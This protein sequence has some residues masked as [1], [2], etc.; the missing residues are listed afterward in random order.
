MAF[1]FDYTMQKCEEAVSTQLIFSVNNCLYAVETPYILEI[2]EIKHVA[3]LP[4][5]APYVL[6]VTKIRDTIYSVMD[7]RI[8]FDTKTE[9]R[10]PAEPAVAI[11][12]TYGGTKMCM[13]V[14][15]VIA[16]VDI[17]LTKASNPAAT[18]H[19]I[20]GIVQVNGMKVA[21]LSIDC[22]FKN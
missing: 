13:V 2:V 5:T 22:L 21:L 12:L 16:V 9:S 7:L 14:D 18:N 1:D 20:G 10:S 19:H 3:A 8:R 4:R 15:K 11:V 17:D 6:G